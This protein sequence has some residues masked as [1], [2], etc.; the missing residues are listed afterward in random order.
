MD[1]QC[2][3]IKVNVDVRNDKFHNVFTARSGNVN[4]PTC[5]GAIA[6]LMP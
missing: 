4:P 2:T 3:D 1:E 6:T 5:A